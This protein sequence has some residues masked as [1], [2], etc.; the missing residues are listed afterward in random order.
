MKIIF[1]AKGQRTRIPQLHKKKQRVSPSTVKGRKEHQKENQPH[2][3]L[4]KYLPGSTSM[5]IALHGKRTG[6]SDASCG[7]P[8]TFVTTC[9]RPD[10][11]IVR[12][13][14]VFPPVLQRAVRSGEYD[15]RFSLVRIGNPRLR[16][17]QHPLIAV[18]TRRCYCGSYRH[19]GRSAQQGTRDTAP[20]GSAQ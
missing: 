7:F 5:T 6:L 8:E 12:S 20:K 2:C 11:G 3:P 1:S 13:P 9:A 4:S 17:V 19:R 16:P 18:E 14:L 15:R 10:G